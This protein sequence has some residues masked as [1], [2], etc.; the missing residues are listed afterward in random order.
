M[1][2]ELSSDPGDFRARDW[3]SLV[4][5]EEDGAAAALA[6][7]VAGL[8]W[9]RADLAGLVSDGRWLPA[10]TRAFERAGLLP[11]EDDDGVT[12]LLVLPSTYEAYEASLP[13]KLRHEA[14]RKARKLERE[15]GPYRLVETTRDTLDAH[16]GR[17]VELH[18]GSKGPKGRFMQ[19]GMEL[20]FRHLADDF[21]APGPFRLTFIEAAGELMAGA[22]SFRFKESVLL[23]NSAFDRAHR[24]LSPGMVLVADMIRQ[25]IADGCRRFDLLK[26]D[27]G[28]KYRFGARPRPVRRL[29][30]SR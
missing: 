22:I 10:L 19:P 27:L 9:A 2:A 3:S 28:Y 16:V 24:A 4:V 18:R 5:G 13:P 30:L 6:D 12:P 14:R 20:F 15:A 29:R 1:R 26:G 17:F 23:Y 11:D 21:L 7:A 25:A 8:G